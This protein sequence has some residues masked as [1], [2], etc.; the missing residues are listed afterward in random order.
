MTRA[1]QIETIRKHLRLLQLKQIVRQLDQVLATAV[2][3]RLPVTDV[4]ETLLEAEANALIE[5]RIERR[6]MEARLPARK[7]L[8]DFDFDFQKSLD[9]A[10]IMQLATLD[11]VQ[12][13]Q[14]V[15]IAGSSGTGKSHLTQALLLLGCRQLYRCRYTTSADMLRYLIAGLADDS[16]EQRLKVYVRPQLL[17]IDEVGFDRVEQ[18]DARRADLFFKVINARY[19]KASTMMT[20]N[21]DFE[22]LGDYLG[23]PVSTTAIVD[24]MV[25]HSIIIHIDGPSYRMHESSK[26]N[27]KRCAT[28]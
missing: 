20:T 3:D 27:R 28:K 19:C 8:A 12:R 10:Q 18:Q 23:D 25:H 14:G 7:T 26:I 5:R 2:R 17:L 9:K 11:F 1:N 13:R 6:I 16:L 21:V 22:M 15:I 24:R 4:L